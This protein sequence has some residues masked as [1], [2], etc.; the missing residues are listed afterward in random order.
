LISKTTKSGKSFLYDLFLTFLMNKQI[1]IQEYYAQLYA[2]HDKLLENIKQD[3]PKLEKLL[4]EVSGHWVYEDMIYRYY[5]YSF[6]V[7][8]VQDNTR[9]IYSALESISP[10]EPKKIP[11]QWFNNIISQGA[12]GIKFELE[13]NQAWE[14]TCRPFLEAFFHAKYFL[15]MAVKYGKEYDKAPNVMGSGWAALAELYNIR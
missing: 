9:K 4:E 2:K 3:L 13:H 15:E 5:H 7:F 14:K 8:M 1:P 11:N 10:H 6:K 12:P